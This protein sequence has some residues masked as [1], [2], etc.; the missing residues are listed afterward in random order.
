MNLKEKLKAK[1][2]GIEDTKPQTIIKGVVFFGLFF[3]ALSLIYAAIY[4]YQNQ[5]L[6][7]SEKYNTKELNDLKVESD[8][9]FI[10]QIVANKTF[11]DST[12]INPLAPERE[13]FFQKKVRLSKILPKND[14]ISKN[15]SVVPK[16]INAIDYY[17]IQKDKES[18]QLGDIGDFLGGYFGVL[19][20]FAGIAFTFIAFYVQYI[21]NK[22]VQ[23]QFRLQQFE[24]QFQ[25]LIDIYLNNKDKF[26]IIGYKNPDNLEADLSLNR[27]TNLFDTLKSIHINKRGQSGMSYFTQPNQPLLTSSNNRIFID[28]NTKDQIVFQKMLV[29]LKSIYRVFLEAYKE[30]NGKREQDLSELIK[31]ELFSL[32]YKTFFK[33]L[34]KFSKEYSED[35]TISTIDEDVIRYSFS[36]LKELRSIYKLDGTK[37]YLNFYKDSRDQWKTLWLK[38]NYEPFKGYLHFLPQ[39]YRNLYTMVKFVVSENSDL[40]LDEDDK[41]KYLRILRSTM[42][43]YEQTMLFYNWYSGIGNDWE[44][45]NNKFFSE[46]K[47][48]HNMKKI[49]LI[50]PQIDIFTILGITPTANFFE[51]Y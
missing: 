36:I 9:V 21:A 33:G 18:F 32:A 10:R 47:M 6:V 48:I 8:T 39:Y 31:K 51:N 19:L 40:D 11:T 4:F 2:K 14:T 13:N 29:E 22:E 30:K 34:N 42:S 7:I 1:L 15:Q 20:G 49:T 44:N 17:I 28:Y 38:V 26:E 23:K 43:D 24:T 5:L 25:K 27:G 16:D 50:D 12:L 46:Y 41:L 3:I 45:N 37:A 35:N